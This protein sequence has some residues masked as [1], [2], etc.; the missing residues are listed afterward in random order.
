MEDDRATGE[1]REPEAHRALK[2]A[3]AGLVFVA[4][5]L[6]FGVG[7]TSYE[8]GSPVRMG[9]GYVPLLLGGI[10]VVLGIAIIVKGFVDPETEP[11]G[12]VPWRATIVLFA[13]VVI[14]GLAVRPLG[15]VPAT[16]V[17]AGL[18]VVASRKASPVSVVAIA[19]GLTAL[20]VVIF[21]FALSLRLPLFGPAIRF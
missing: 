12:T 4:F 5:G 17:A 7:A 16:L 19:I 13:A 18:A 8:I 15:L 3:L 11:I 2:D 20:C 1:R 21:A 10:L 6:G 9:P 14:F